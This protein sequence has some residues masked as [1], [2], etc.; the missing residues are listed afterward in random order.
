MNILEEYIMKVPS[1]KNAID[2]F[3]GEWAS[4]IPGEYVSGN[5]DL[6]HDGRMGL[7]SEKIGGF[8][9]KDILELGPL[10]AAHTYMMTK[11]GA[12]RILAI[13]A[14]SRAYVKCLIV[15]EV[16]ALENCSFLLGDFDLHLEDT[17]DE[18]DLIMALGVLYHCINPIKTIVNMTKRAK[19][20]GIWSH[21]FCESIIR[22][23]YGEKFDYDP[24]LLSFEGYEATC[25]EHHYREALDIPGFCGGGRSS[26][27]WMDKNSW[28]S[29]FDSLGYELDILSE[30][31]SHQNGPEFTAV[32]VAIP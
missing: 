4:Q 20:I 9:G 32:A 5:A 26:T 25:Y 16:L 14:N 21:Y 30:S 23:K 7:I 27:R 6:F 13:E 15:K 2:L 11:G 17:Q 1:Q 8:S 28:L 24:T 19:V 3:E 29:L 18:Y 22:E 12:N 10:E 31:T